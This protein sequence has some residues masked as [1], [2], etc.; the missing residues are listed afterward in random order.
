MNYTHKYEAIGLPWQTERAINVSDC[1]TAREVIEKAHLDYHVSKCNLMAQMPIN[2][3]IPETDSDNSD[4]IGFNYEGKVYRKCPNVYATYRTD[5]NVPLGFVK[6]KYEIVQNI[7]AFNF[8]DDAIGPDKAIWQTAGCFGYGQKMF[9]SAKLPFTTQVH[10]DPIDHYLVFSNSHDGT[11]SVNIMFTP[12]RILCFNVLNCAKRKAD[13]YIRIRHTKSAKEK[14]EQGAEILSIAAKYVTEAQQLYETLYTI[15]MSDEDVMK[16]LTKLVLNEEE[17]RKL[18]EY[19]ITPFKRLIN[20]DMMVLEHTGVSMRK[21][22]TVAKM[23]D[24]YQNG[25]AQEPIAGT[26]WGAYNAVTGYF[27]NV[28]TEKNLKRMNDLLYGSD[29]LKMQN[30]FNSALEVPELVEV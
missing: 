16:Y 25:V 11:S 5:K 3:N 24:Y 29:N 15:K 13:A 22:N 17:E 23:Y 14:I 8:F 12:V 27:S 10:N 4:D 26:A 1:K 28:N 6:E 9:I 7:D 30:A 20:K 19:D 2:I 18:E 21:A